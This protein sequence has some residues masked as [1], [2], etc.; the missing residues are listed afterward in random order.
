MKS[1]GFPDPQ[2]V[3]DRLGDDFVEALVDAVDGAR[4]DY[5][6]LKAWRP[7]WAPSYSSRFIANFA[8]ERIWARLI[9]E[10]DGAPGIHIR[11]EE[12][13]REILSGTA[14]VTRVKRHH[15][16]DRISA[17]PTTGSLAHWSNRAL[18]LEG[19]ESISLAAGYYWDEETRDIGAPVL[20]LR[21]EK[22]KPV[23][24]ITLHRDA[25][26]PTAIQ[27]APVEPGLPEFD[28]S[29]IAIEDEEEGLA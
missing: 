8:H 6:D 11:D 15:P 18:T 13:V 5:A 28:L 17:Y 29:Q 19:L 21:E 16:G 1:L 25:A 7:E 24:G 20:S 12:P 4:E 22:D 26:Q 9:R 27:W 14:F 10:I 3:I 23:W 2:K